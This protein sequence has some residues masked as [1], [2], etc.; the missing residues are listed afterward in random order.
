[1][2]KIL[3][4][5]YVSAIIYILLI[6]TFFLRTKDSSK[7]RGLFSVMLM[8]GLLATLYDICTVLLDNSGV[9][10]VTLKYITNIGYLILRN[11]IAPIY[12]AYII[13][14]TETWHLLKIRKIMTP[15]ILAP[16][17]IVALLTLS[18]PVNHL[19][20]YIGKGDLYTRGPLF[21]VLYISALYYLAFC[22]YYCMKYRSILNIDR[23]IPLISII[24]FSII[25]V[26][27]Q[28]IF[29][30]AL[31]EMISTVLCLL[32]IMITIERPE[33]TIDFSTGL[34]KSDAFLNSLINNYNVGKS[35]SLTVINTTN[36]TALNNCLSYK[37]MDNLFV[38]VAER[39]K[40]TKKQLGIDPL[41]YNL[42]NGMFV[43]AFYNKDIAFAS[44]FASHAIENLK[45]DFSING[46]SVSIM[47]NACIIKVPEDVNTVDSIRFLIRDFR[48]KEYQNE[49]FHAS[50]F[51]K[52]KDYNI[53][54]NIDSILRHAIDNDEF[55][56]YYQPIYST[57]EKRF[58][59]CE[60]LIRLV[61]KDYGFIRPDLFIPLSEESGLIHEIGLIVIDKVCKFIS[62]EEF[63][64]L[65]LDYVEINLSTVQCMDY[66]LPDKIMEKISKYNV[67][68]SQINLE[69]T[70]TAS[71]I[72]Q[73]N[74]LS[75]INTLHERGFSFSLD[76]FG[77]GYS[78]MVRISSLPLHI[79]KLDRSFTWTEGNDSLK[80]I[81]ENTIKMIKHMNMRIVAEGIETKD[82]LDSFTDYGCEYIQGYYFSKPL[83]EFD[84]V[85]FIKDAINN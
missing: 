38:T 32:L 73:K 61:T 83:P 34:Y 27:V 5:D 59:S 18:A 39:L 84:F 42:E 81:L 16:F 76:D 40:E 71:S 64:K 56:V 35:F 66:D 22:A 74:L 48:R 31:C 33:E 54:A 80:T 45:K 79:V 3:Y 26:I 68:P 65:N 82:M 11:A 72:S 69:I 43:A 12:G 46:L 53:M 28:F 20:F 21:F 37:N 10:A 62:S 9:G 58:N 67:N 44:R 2:A 30:D 55:E 47:P 23:L 4:L 15:I 1:M 85:N 60:A 14:Y 52:S 70:E 36:Y 50:S 41:I 51:V 24:P 6:I 25:A 77:T 13:T 63:K 49:I 8:V 75:N 17:C 19:I 78:N 29:P 7:R 57:K